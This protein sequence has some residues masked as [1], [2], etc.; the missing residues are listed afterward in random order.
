[1]TR[2]T[3]EIPGNAMASAASVQR[4]MLKVANPLYIFEARFEVRDALEFHLK[5]IRFKAPEHPGG[6]WLGI[7]TMLNSDGDMIG[8]HRGD[9]L[10][11][12]VK[13]LFNRLNNGNMKW[14]EDEYA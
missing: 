14:K 13:G 10:T 4:A 9:S 7:V 2:G 6:E 11:D 12:V 1:M 8:F 3:D 5:A